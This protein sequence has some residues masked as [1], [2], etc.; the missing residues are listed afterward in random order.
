MAAQASLASF[1]P[2]VAGLRPTPAPNI[3]H[4]TNATGPAKDGAILKSF[5]Q[6][7]ARPKVAPR[8]PDL[9]LTARQYGMKDEMPTITFSPAEY[10]AANQRFAHTLIAK[11]QLGRS[12]F[13]VVTNTMLNA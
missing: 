10:Q 6:V 8:F 5:A 13:E 11:F 9:Q 3:I 7:I 1:Q 4:G 2:P 12:P